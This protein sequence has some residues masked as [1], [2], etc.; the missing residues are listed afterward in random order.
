MEPYLIL[1]KY[2]F[3]KPLIIK[4]LIMSVGPVE[5]IRAGICRFYGFL[6]AEEIKLAAGLVNS[7]IHNRLWFL[8][9]LPPAL[10]FPSTICTETNYS[11]KDFIKET[12]K[13]NNLPLLDRVIV[14]GGGEAIVLEHCCETNNLPVIKHIMETYYNFSQPGSTSIQYS[15]GFNGNEEIIDYL[16]SLGMELYIVFHIGAC[17]GKQYAALKKY[18]PAKIKAYLF[19]VIKYRCSIEMIEFY[20]SPEFLEDSL[21]FAKSIGNTEAAEFLSTL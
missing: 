15:L 17:D 12:V 1:K 6:S 11:D 18:F 3:N 10:N 16:I 20:Y 19:N 9:F 14:Y 4:I 8:G 7:G 21:R 2:K 5:M 13:L